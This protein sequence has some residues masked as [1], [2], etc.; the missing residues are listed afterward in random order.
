MMRI[1]TIFNNY[2]H[3]ITI[4]L[5]DTEI[6]SKSLYNSLISLK[7]LMKGEIKNTWQITIKNM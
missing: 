4:K 5:I 7:F 3:L 2:M 6:S 1:C